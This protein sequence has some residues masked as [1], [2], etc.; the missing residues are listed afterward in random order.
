MRIALVVNNLGRDLAGLSLLATELC[1]NGATVFLVPM[2]LQRRELAAL[3]PNF[4]LFNQLRPLN[5]PVVQELAESG[6]KFGVLDDEGGVFPNFEWYGRQLAQETNTR[7]AAALFC[8][9]GNKLASHVAKEGWYR[10]DAVRVTGH[11]RFDFYAPYWKQFEFEN[12]FKSDNVTRPLILI[13][14]RFSRANPAFG[15]TEDEVQTLIKSRGFSAEEA[16]Q[17]QKQM[18]GTLHGMAEMTGRLAEQFPGVDF[19]LRPHPFER[20][21]TYTELLKSPGNIYVTREGSIGNWL[22]IASGVIHRS[23]TT[24]IEASMSNVPAFS[25][26]W[27][28]FPDDIESTER[29]SIQCL[30]H[31]ELT[32]Y[33][34]AIANGNFQ[35]VAQDKESVIADWF[36]A[37]DGKAHQR[38]AQGITTVLQDT[39]SPNINLARCGRIAQGI[40]P[41][42]DSLRALISRAKQLRSDKEQ[43]RVDKWVQSSR[44]FTVQD[45]EA[46][47]AKIVKC[48]NWPVPRVEAATSH[49]RC[50]GAPGYSVALRS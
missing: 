50:K 36:Y 45:V 21:E 5:Q 38:V 16:Q 7:H 33:I 8:S 27:I 41:D 20:L 35:T 18:L 47:V 3:A 25:A 34:S 6:I 42:A 37:V 19:V 14:T 23:C 29:V 44:S 12:P 39:S 30:S 9:W 2:P 15:S 46:I 43:Q 28:P 40:K 24:A 11:P 13:N 22:R 32:E 1:S 26:R 31:E 49:Y 48:Q 10:A 17:Y 4:I